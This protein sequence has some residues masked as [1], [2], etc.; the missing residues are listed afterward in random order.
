MNANDQQP[1]RTSWFFSRI[2]PRSNFASGDFVLASL[3]SCDRCFVCLSGR[4]RFDSGC[5]HDARCPFWYMREGCAHEFLRDGLRTLMTY[6]PT[7][8]SRTFARGVVVGGASS[9]ARV[10]PYLRSEKAQTT[11]MLRLAASNLARRAS[12][13]LSTAGARYVNL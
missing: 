7:P 5:A 9:S 11:T 12:S 1:S 13:S 3:L 2:L 4:R 10:S 8:I 6:Q